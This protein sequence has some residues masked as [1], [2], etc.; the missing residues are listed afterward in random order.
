[1]YTFAPDACAPAKLSAR[2]RVS[3][4]SDMEKRFRRVSRHGEAAPDFSISSNQQKTD[5]I[6]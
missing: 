6:A 2:N 3:D 5:M 4:V 1:M